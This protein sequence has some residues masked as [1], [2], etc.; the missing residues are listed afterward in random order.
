MNNNYLNEE[1]YQKVKKV[2]K[3]IGFLSIAVGVTLLIISFIIKTP[4][5]GEP[6]WYDSET[7]KQM[8]RALAFVFGLM[9]PMVTLSIAYGREI[10]SFQMQQHMPIAQES[11]KTMAPTVGQA[12]KEIAKEMA[13]AY[14][15]IAKEMA[16]VYGEIAKEVGK[17]IA[18]GINEANHS[19]ENK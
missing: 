3:I 18:E 19:S 13:P 11:I 12:G 15:E 14:G 10:A 6:G 9:I 8:L 7:R 16:P 1:K 17:G 4:K 5:M 2:L